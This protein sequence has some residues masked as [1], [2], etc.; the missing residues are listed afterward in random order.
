MG[1]V[2]SFIIISTAGFWAYA[3]YHRFGLSK[4]HKLWLAYYAIFIVGGL[5]VFD[6]LMYFGFF[7]T[8]VIPLINT[9]PWL[10]EEIQSGRDFMW[11][12]FQ[13]IGIDWNI[14]YTDN[15]LNF[16]AIVLI[17]SYPMWFKFFS[18]GSR[19][20]FGGNEP[21][22]VGSWY[23]FEPTHKPKEGEKVAQQPKET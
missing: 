18:N 11:N 9:I 15:G 3:L 1:F 21:Y 20:L 22:L 2:T 16:I 8:S 5:M 19:M 12:S 10:P 13:L 17:I 23:L 6:F 4:G 14:N 7:D